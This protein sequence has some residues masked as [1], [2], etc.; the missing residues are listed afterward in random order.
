VVRAAYRLALASAHV[1]VAAVEISEFPRIAQQLGIRAVPMTVLSGRTVIAGAV[2]EA[3]LAEHVTKTASG[4]TA[5]QTQAGAVTTATA[6]EPGAEPADP[7]SGHIVP[8]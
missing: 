7:G 3:T 4:A 5:G 8:R 2:D 1:E 6:F